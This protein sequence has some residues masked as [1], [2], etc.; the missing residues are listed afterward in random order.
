MQKVYRGQAVTLSVPLI[1]LH[2]ITL[3]GHGAATIGEIEDIEDMP[4]L[5]R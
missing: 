1:A 4:S 3:T 5:C 2:A